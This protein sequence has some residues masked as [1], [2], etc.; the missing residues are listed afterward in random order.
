MSKYETEIKSTLREI[1]LYV[2]ADLKYVE[3]AQLHSFME[4]FL[5]NCGGKI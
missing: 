3:Y 4:W 2:G 1:L 5:R